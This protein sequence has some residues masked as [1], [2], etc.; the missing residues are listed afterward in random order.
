[1]PDADKNFTISKHPMSIISVSRL[2]LYFTMLSWQVHLIFMLE[3]NLNNYNEMLRYEKDMDLLRALALWI[4]NHDSSYGLLGLPK[5]REY[6]FEIIKKYSQEFAVDIDSHTGISSDTLSRFH[7][8]LFSLNRLLGITDEDVSLANEQQRY[9]NSGFW[10]MRRVIGQFG[11]VAECAKNDGVS[12]IITAAVSGC[13]VGEYLALQFD[14]IHNYQIPVDHMVF[15]RDGS[16]PIG[17]MLPES[18][19]LSGNHILLVDDAVMETFTSRVMVRE[20]RK[21][22]PD[23]QISLMTIDIDP[24]TKSSGYLDQFTRVYTFEE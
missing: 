24:D 22:K 11:D 14:K 1:M 4:T 16:E 5:P 20:M 8:A 3:I 23:L 6:V 13:I 2:P 21:L 15:S 12:H 19:E 17:G 7:S 10:E 18:F 9:K